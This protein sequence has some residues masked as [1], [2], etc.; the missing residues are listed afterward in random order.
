MVFYRYSKT[1]RSTPVLPVIATD[2][3]PLP[4]G[5]N[6]LVANTYAQ[7]T[8]CVSCWWSE[9]SL[10]VSSKSNVIDMFDTIPTWVQRWRQRRR[11]GRQ[12]TIRE[13]NGRNIWGE[14][15]WARPHTIYD[16]TA[17]AFFLAVIST[18]TLQSPPQAMPC[19]FALCKIGKIFR[20][21]HDTHDANTLHGH[22]AVKLRPFQVMSIR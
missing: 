19:L 5:P 21:T 13:N 7:M 11:S 22:C 2:L 1:T 17:A 9:R 14:T 12:T 10:R 3:Y 15:L 8:S 20:Y 18:S 4:Y 16:G 6:T